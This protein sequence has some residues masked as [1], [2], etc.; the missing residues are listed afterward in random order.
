MTAPNTQ[1]ISNYSALQRGA[2]ALV[3]AVT[4]SGSTVYLGLNDTTTAASAT[5]GSASALPA[6]PAGYVEALVG[7]VV[8][9]IPFYNA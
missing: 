8:Y 2:D 9:K 3:T 5:T 6:L 1:K 4:A 7:G